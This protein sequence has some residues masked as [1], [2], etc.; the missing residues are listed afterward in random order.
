MEKVIMEK[1][2]LIEQFMKKGI[3][4]DNCK[5][6]VIDIGMEDAVKIY[7]ECYGDTRLI[8]INIP[9]Y[10]GPVI[11]ETE[12]CAA[13]SGTGKY[14]DTKCQVCSG[15]G[16]YMG[17]NKRL[18]DTECRFCNRTGMKIKPEM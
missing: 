13:C 14:I 18:I 8:D 12:K 6:I 7:Y 11:G 17:T 2:E 16:K 10:L 15:T 1:G 4:P 3:V 5:R 9:Q